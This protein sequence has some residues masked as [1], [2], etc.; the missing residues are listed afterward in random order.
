MTNDWKA[1]KSLNWIDTWKE[2]ERIYRAHPEK[3]K[4]I[5]VHLSQ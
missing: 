3:V 5:G 2:M 1:D 4:A